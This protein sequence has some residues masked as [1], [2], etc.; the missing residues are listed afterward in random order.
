MKLFILGSLLFISTIN[1]ETVKQ[2][3]I[4]QFA[5]TKSDKFALIL[6]NENVLYYDLPNCPIEQVTEIVKQPDSNM[7]VHGHYVHDNTKV[8]IFSQKKRGVTCNIERIA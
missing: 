1:A 5:I 6:K 4:H 8:T 7:F 2:S 3:E